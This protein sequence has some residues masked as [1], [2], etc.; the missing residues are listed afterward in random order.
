MR[1]C[2]EHDENKFLVVQLPNEQ[3]VGLDVTLPLALAVAVKLM[4]MVFLF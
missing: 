3:P 1:S 4:D 2:V